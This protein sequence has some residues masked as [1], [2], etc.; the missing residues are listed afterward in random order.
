M[1][2]LFLTNHWAVTKE[3]ARLVGTHPE[4]LGTRSRVSRHQWL[5]A[6]AWTR[7]A[8]T[9][10]SFDVQCDTA[11][12]LARRCPGG[13][14][15]VMIV[16]APG[17]LGLPAS[18]EDAPCPVVAC[19]SDWPLVLTGQEGMLD[20]YDYL[21][22][23]RAGVRVLKQMGYQNAEYWP[24]YAHDPVQ[25]R[26]IANTEKVWDIGMVGNLSPVVQRERA[27][28]LARVARLADR[29]RVR[30]AGGVFNEDYARMLNATKI[31]FN[32]TFKVRPN[33]ALLGA[34]N[35]RCYEAAACGSLLFCD[36]DNEEIRE[37]FEDRVHC[38]LY[39]EQNL[40]ELLDYYLSHGEERE[41][42]TAAAVERIAEHSFVHNLNRL[43]DRLQ[44]LDLIS[45][46][47]KRQTR[48]IPTPERLKRRARQLAGTYTWR[49][50][51]AAAAGLRIALDM[52]PDDAAAHNDFAVINCWAMGK[53]P[54]VNACLLTDSLQHLRRAVELCPDSAFYQLN[55]AQMY[56]AAGFPEAALELAQQALAL[57]GSD[58]EDPA[59]IFCLP[60]P[61]GWDEYR[62]QYSLLY[63]ATRSA[64]ETFPILRRCLLLY[65]GGM[66]LGRLAEAQGLLPMAAVGYR[67]AVTARPDLGSGHAALARVLV[68]GEAGAGPVNEAITHLATALQSDPFILEAWTLSVELLRRQGLEAEARAFLVERLTMLEALC[69][70]RERRA[71]SESLSE[72]E[73]VREA[74][75]Q[76]L[77]SL[78]I[79][80]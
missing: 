7:M 51:Q 71:M 60:F 77:E 52:N 46:M 6:V 24:L 72:L 56:A 48:Q 45:R 11:C 32:Y 25:A 1:R 50:P 73:E 68:Q 74:L 4:L 43:A 35:M 34:M 40:E 57:L 27:P 61:F 38:V 13:I 8:A 70:A 31:T 36:E 33:R 63:A 69:P 16:W 58:R 19:L 49:A 47:S 23:D 18:I 59:D 9:D 78:A 37:F 15:D 5:R 14:P 62:V 3:P 10:I 28:W 20:S 17:Y 53:N 66:L 75:T 67:V 79:A 26:V 21:F 64:P 2:I 39:N 55:L 65:R 12:D 44:Q 54:E 22:T 30:I 80:A 29:Y 42:I 41:R 76:Q